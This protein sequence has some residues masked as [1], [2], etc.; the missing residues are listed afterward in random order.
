MAK[1]PILLRLQ[2][3]LRAKGMSPGMATAVA[4]KTLQKSGSLK[5]GTTS[6]TARGDKRSAMGAAGRAKDRAAKASGHKASDFGYS[7]KT[8]RATLRGGK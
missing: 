7:S 3:Q 1:P 6:A 8:N 2:Q 4:T 5:P